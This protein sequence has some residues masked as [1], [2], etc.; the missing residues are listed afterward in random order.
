MVLDLLD[1]DGLPGEDLAEI[2][3]L[4]LEADAPAGG[5]GDRLVVER[6]VELGQ[7]GIGTLR[8]LRASMRSPR[9]CVPGPARYRGD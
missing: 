2:D 7:A 9:L 8:R 6:I 3:L 5:D 4:P 1:A